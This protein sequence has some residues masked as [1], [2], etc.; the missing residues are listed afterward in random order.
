MGYLLQLSS[1]RSVV[2]VNRIRGRNRYLG[3]P[4]VGSG[5]FA[6]L[7]IIHIVIRTTGVGS[8]AGKITR[9]TQVFMGHPG[10]DDHNVAFPQL[11]GEA[12]F[13][14]EDHFLDPAVDAE[15]LVSCAMVMMEPENPVMP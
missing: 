14:A 6:R 9:R 2:P 12:A 11:S 1:Q 4:L 8:D 13:A 10:R 7:T 5:P 15:D 3:Y